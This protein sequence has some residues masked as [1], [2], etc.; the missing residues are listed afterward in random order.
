MLENLAL[1]RIPRLASV[2]SPRDLAQDALEI[3][4]KL[5]WTFDPGAKT[6]TLEVGSK[7]KLEILKV[8]SSDPRAVI[9]DEPTAVLSGPEVD[10][11]FRVLRRLRDDGRIV[12]LIAHKLRE[13][14]EIA[15]RVTVLRRGS[16][17]ATAQ[18]G[19]YDEAQLATWMVGEMPEFKTFE[20][21]DRS[22]EGLAVSDLTVLGDR[23]EVAVRGVNFEVKKGEIL[24]IGGVDG[25]G[26]VE[27]AEAI[28]GVRPIAGGKIGGI[29]AIGY[30]PQD[31][32][33]DG[34][35]KGLNIAENMLPPSIRKF[36]SGPFLKVASI[37]GWAAGLIS[38][39]EI[40]APGPKSQAGSLSGGN[41]QKVVVSRVLDSNPDLLVVSGPSRGLDVRATAFVWNAIRSARDLGAAV[42]LFSA[43]LDELSQLADRTLF[44]SGGRLQAAQDAASLLGG[45]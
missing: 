30:V 38:K 23:G 11:L 29:S 35:A 6:E 25:N 2:C 19:E 9:F 16:V 22:S 8:L 44:M 27:L 34:L 43:D 21:G 1:A 28:A 32:S 20:K 41:Q 42:L 12:V 5:G 36:Q 45:K 15:D 17:V 14:M 18:R 26:Q 37:L 31:R 40:A 33:R 3:G 24:G 7:Q 13:V 39:F 4:G 10:E